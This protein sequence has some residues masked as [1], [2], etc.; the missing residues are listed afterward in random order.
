MTTTSLH[1]RPKELAL[2]LVDEFSA[3]MPALK[4]WVSS[5]LPQ[6]ELT[7]PRIRLLY[8]LHRLGPQIMTDLSGQLGVS[9]RDIT[10]LV[11]ALE[12]DKLV[13]RCPHPTDRRATYIELTPQGAED[14][15]AIYS[16]YR[17][18]AAELF[19]E[20]SESDLRELLRLLTVLRSVLKLKGIYFQRLQGECVAAKNTEELL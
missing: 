7:Y 2:Q 4:R 20:L 10:A 5:S 17:R 3:L 18:V 8:A 16:E 6:G 9:P 1:D 15:I 13:K 11:D 14:C 12:R 19:S